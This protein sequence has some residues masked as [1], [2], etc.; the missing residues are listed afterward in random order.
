MAIDWAPCGLGPLG[1][2]LYHLVGI[3]AAFFDFGVERIREF[4]EH[5]FAAHLHGLHSAGWAGDANQAR[6]WLHLSS[7]RISGASWP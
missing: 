2:D 7:T 5:A 6:C 1:S 4:D 3:S